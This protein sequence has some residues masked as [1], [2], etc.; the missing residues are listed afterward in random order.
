[1]NSNLPAIVDY[2]EHAL[3]LAYSDYRFALLLERLEQ[4]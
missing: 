2:A 1:M 3:S 4:G